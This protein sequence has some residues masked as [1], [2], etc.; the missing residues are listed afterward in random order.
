VPQ[1]SDLRPIA[2]RA[3]PEGWSQAAPAALDEGVV[4]VFTRTVI[5]W[6][7][8]PHAEAAL[9]WAA[10]RAGDEVLELVH[11]IAGDDQA[12]EYLR[13]TGDLSA[14]RVALMDRAEALRAEHPGRTVE[15]KTVHGRPEREL[16]ARLAHDVLVIVGTSAHGRESAWTLGARLAAHRS[17]GCV[18]VIPADW[19]AD[20]RRNI[21][22]GVDGSVESMA[23]VR[24]GVEE[25]QRSGD[26]LELVHSWVVPTSWNSAYVEYLGDVQLME[27]MRRDV[28]DEALDYARS[29]GGAPAG[30]LEQGGAAPILAERSRT[31]N[32][33]IVGSHATGGMARFLLGSVSHDLLLEAA[34]P[35]IVVS[36]NE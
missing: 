13:A 29:L 32:A 27:D 18:A 19:D 34:G 21:V 17:R 1:P 26:E 23:A 6:D 22:V 24:V 9:R 16:G 31:A 8:S 30:R 3:V 14:Q 2:P 15:T 11:V 7:G 5:A 4:Q 36:D 10:G 33:V 20:G 25:A 12:S 28:L 35:V